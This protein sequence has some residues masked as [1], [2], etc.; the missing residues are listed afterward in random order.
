LNGEINRQVQRTAPESTHLSQFHGLT[1]RLAGSGE[2][3]VFKPEESGH[4]GADVEVDGDVVSTIGEGAGVDVPTGKQF[5]SPCS[6]KGSPARGTRFWGCPL[7][8]RDSA[9]VSYPHQIFSLTIS[10]LK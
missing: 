10:E 8:V 7:A 4:K 9:V 1:Q 3:H 5:E 6:K 2:G